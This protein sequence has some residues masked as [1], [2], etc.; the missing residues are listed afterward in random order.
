M[1]AGVIQLRLA[2]TT[3]DNRTRT[4]D[5]AHRRQPPTRAPR[6]RRPTTSANA[7]PTPSSNQRSARGTQRH[8]TRRRRR[9]MA[10][11]GEGGR[12]RAAEGEGGTAEG[13]DRPHDQHHVTARSAVR[14]V[15]RECHPR[16]A[17]SPRCTQLQPDPT[18]ART[19]ATATPA[20]A[21]AESLTPRT[22]AAGASQRRSTT[23]DRARRTQDNSAPR[24]TLHDGRDGTTTARTIVEGVRCTTTTPSPR[25]RNPAICRV[26]W[27]GDAT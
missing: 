11:E 16:A 4:A 8:T 1:W 23:D 26:L 24:A 21:N 20:L 9:G 15:R 2:R 7:Q 25:T 12:G 27:R 19:S 17:T 3:M 5:H 18:S 22:S 6:H 13:K 14:P 10:V